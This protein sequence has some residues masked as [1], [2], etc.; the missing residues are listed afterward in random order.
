MRIESS[1]C[2][3]VGLKV[4]PAVG[5]TPKKRPTNSLPVIFIPNDDRVWVVF[6]AMNWKRKRENNQKWT[7]WY[8]MYIMNGD[9]LGWQLKL[10]IVNQP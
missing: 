10:Q 2:M 8:N 3:S 7:V 9:H 5:S 1:L 4:M 6:F